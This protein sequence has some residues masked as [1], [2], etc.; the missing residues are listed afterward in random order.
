MK[1]D[2]AAKRKFL[3]A[4]IQRLEF[5]PQEDILKI[6]FFMEPPLVCTLTGARDRT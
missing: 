1:Q 2:I 6:Y 4:F 3:R 5:D